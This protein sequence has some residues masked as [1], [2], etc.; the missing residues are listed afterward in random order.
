MAKNFY[1]LDGE[2]NTLYHGRDQ[3]D[4]PQAFGTFAAAEKRAKKFADTE[5]GTEVRIVKVEAI[6]LAP[7]MPPKTRRI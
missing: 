5:P 1:V 7:V 2:G 3:D 4:C 6:V